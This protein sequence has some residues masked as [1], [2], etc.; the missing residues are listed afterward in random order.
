VAISKRLEAARQRLA[1]SGNCR[2]Y[3]ILDC[4]PHMLLVLVVPRGCEHLPVSNPQGASFTMPREDTTAAWGRMTAP[5]LA[6]ID[7]E[8]LPDEPPPTKLRAVTPK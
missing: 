1:A 2:V 5:T 3:T 4:S 6:T 7:A 8:N